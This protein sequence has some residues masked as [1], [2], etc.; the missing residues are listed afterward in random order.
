MQDYTGVLEKAARQT[1]EKEG[2][3]AFIRLLPLLLFL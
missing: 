3:A 2:G 1:G